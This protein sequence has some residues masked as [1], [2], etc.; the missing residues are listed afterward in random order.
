MAVTNSSGVG[1]GLA[2][3]PAFEEFDACLPGHLRIT[4]ICQ[5]STGSAAAR[6]SIIA[7]HVPD[8]FKSLS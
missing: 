8:D 4:F 5:G 2:P 3:A 6:R 1:A 7:D